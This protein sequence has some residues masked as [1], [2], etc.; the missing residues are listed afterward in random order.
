M[1]LRLQPRQVMAPRQWPWVEV[2]AWLLLLLLLLGG[3]GR[4]P[5]VAEAK[6]AATPPSARNGRRQSQRHLRRMQWPP[7]LLPLLLPLPP[8][9]SNGTNGPCSPLPHCRC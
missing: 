8:R 7:L 2:K 3:C 6:T 5:A 1:Q 9:A 4:A